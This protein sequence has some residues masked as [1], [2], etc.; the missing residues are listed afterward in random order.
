[1]DKV[2][3]HRG[4]GIVAMGLFE[5]GGIDFL[6]TITP[7]GSSLVAIPWWDGCKYGHANLVFIVYSPAQCCL[8][9][10][11][12]RAVLVL[13]AVTFEVQNMLLLTAL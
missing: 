3:I 12:V 8:S 11:L 10:Q 2:L 7:S 9:F 1:M 6:S 4:V 5:C 13:A